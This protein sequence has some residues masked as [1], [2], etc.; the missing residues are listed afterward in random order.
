M[1]KKTA[2]VAYL[3][4]PQIQWLEQKRDQGYNK[5]S[6]IR[7]LIKECMSKKETNENPAKVKEWRKE[8][9]KNDPFPETIKVSD[10]KEST[11]EVE[12]AKAT[13]NSNKAEKNS[14]TNE[15]E[16]YPID[17]DN[18]DLED[19]VA[20]IVARND[21]NEQE[22]ERYKTMDYCFKNLK[23]IDPETA[24]LLGIWKGSILQYLAR[25]E[26]LEG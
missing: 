2:I 3:D 23:H 21:P 13:T 15:V 26:A 24:F 9:R 10:S 14:G 12:E 8:E 20:A 16:R 18:K 11:K 5:S 17:V 4:E 6:I 1:A 19:E 25:C 7:M 22:L